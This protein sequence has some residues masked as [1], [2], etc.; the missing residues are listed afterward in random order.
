MVGTGVGGRGGHGHRFAI[1]CVWTGRVR[2]EHVGV[3]RADEGG[4][5]VL[6]VGLGAVVPDDGEC[7][8]AVHVDL[9]VLLSSVLLSSA[10]VLLLVLCLHVDTLLV[11]HL[12]PVGVTGRRGLLRVHV[13]GAV[14]LIELLEEGAAGGGV[15]CEG[16]GPESL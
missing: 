10:V 11:R 1:E 3:L 4:G 14:V 5:K 9:R 8:T 7:V 16:G 15:L 12:G 6:L 2:A 13:M